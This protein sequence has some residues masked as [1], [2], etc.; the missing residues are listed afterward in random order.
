MIN[1]GDKVR[2]KVTGFTG[3]AVVRSTY[4]NGCDRICIQPEVKKD[5]IMPDEKYFDE[6]QLEVVGKPKVKQKS[7]RTTGGPAY[8][9][10][11]EKSKPSAR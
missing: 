4:L 5:G 11:T 8:Y 1:L 9:I 6:P 2:D 7:K 10:P 3:I